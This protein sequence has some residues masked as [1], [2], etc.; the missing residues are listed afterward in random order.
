MKLTKRLKALL[1]KYK[2]QEALLWAKYG[3]RA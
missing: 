2:R 3:R 1:K